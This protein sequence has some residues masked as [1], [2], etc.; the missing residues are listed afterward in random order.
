MWQA[1]LQLRPISH[2]WVVQPVVCQRCPFCNHLSML[3]DLQMLIQS[4][5]SISIHLQHP[6]TLNCV[7]SEVTRVHVSLHMSR[8]PAVTHT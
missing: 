3:T 5:P 2:R 4:L 7:R 1:C 6:E 8:G